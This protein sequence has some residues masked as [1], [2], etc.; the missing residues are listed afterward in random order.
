MAVPDAVMDAMETV[1]ANVRLY[2]LTTVQHGAQVD[3]QETVL[4]VAQAYVVPLVEETVHIIVQDIV[5]DAEEDVLI[6]I[7]LLWR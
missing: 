5:E 6:V 2:A 7:K 4:V 1:R 3:V